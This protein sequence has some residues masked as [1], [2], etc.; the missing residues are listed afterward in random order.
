M[1]KMEDLEEILDDL[2]IDINA[3]IDVYYNSASIEHEDEIK[4]LYR[5]RFI[6]WAADIHTNISNLY[7]SKHWCGTI[8]LNRRVDERNYDRKII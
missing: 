4:E 7:K 2:F 8:D 3:S 5:K 6:M 1:I